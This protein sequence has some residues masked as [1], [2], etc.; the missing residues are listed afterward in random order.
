MRLNLFSRFKMPLLQSGRGQFQRNTVSQMVSGG[1]FI[2]ASLLL[3]GVL[4]GPI[5]DYYERDDTYQVSHSGITR[6]EAQLS[7]AL[8]AAHTAHADS[9]AYLTWEG[10]PLRSTCSSTRACLEESLRRL[11]RETHEEEF[12]AA[13]GQDV[14]REW[15]EGT[16]QLK[17]WE[18]TVLAAEPDAPEGQAALAL[19]GSNLLFARAKGHLQ[20]TQ[21]RLAIHKEQLETWTRA[22]N[23]AQMT[24]VFFLECFCIGLMLLSSWHRQRIGYLKDKGLKVEHQ[25]NSAVDAIDDRVRN[26][27]QLIDALIEIQREESDPARQRQVLESLASDI[28]AIATV[29]TFQGAARLHDALPA[30]VLLR[31]LIGQRLGN[32]HSVLL[33]LEAITLSVRK[34]TSLA[35][36]VNE[37]LTFTTERGA[38]LEAMELCLDGREVKLNLRFADLPRQVEQE[39]TGTLMMETLVRHDLRGEI[40]YRQDI[41]L[42]Q[43]RFPSDE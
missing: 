17:R 22:A 3:L 11:D 28:R 2:L 12:I 38:H 24:R 25:L 23:E 37:L 18:E 31:R 10:P 8:Q 36:I 19:Q 42:I 21:S 32:P 5:A 40:Q 20:N 35:L 43:V 41:P 30:N 7:R 4:L 6:A 1:V 14:L 34:S 16:A 29:H 9:L 33:N 15:R 13:G 39:E 27:L 26:M